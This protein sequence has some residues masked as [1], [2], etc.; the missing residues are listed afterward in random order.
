[1]PRR[2]HVRIRHVGRGGLHARK[3]L[4]PRTQPGSS[5]I[6]DTSLRNYET[7]RSAATAQAM[8]VR[9]GS[10]SCYNNHSFRP[11]HFVQGTFSANISHAQFNKPLF[12]YFQIP[13]C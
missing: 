11:L 5:P 1:M 8:V 7:P 4:L 2:G 13:L 9:Y 6:S 10:Q 3:R 12:F